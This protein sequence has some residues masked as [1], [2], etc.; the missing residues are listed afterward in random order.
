MIEVRRVSVTASLL[1]SSVK[2]SFFVEAEHVLWLAAA[3]L[4]GGLHAPQTRSGRGENHPFTV[5]DQSADS[6]AKG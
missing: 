4:Q 3:S 1:H 5:S 2:Q 6:A